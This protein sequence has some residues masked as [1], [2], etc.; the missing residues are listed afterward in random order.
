MDEPE[1]GERETLPHRV[2][3]Q[4]DAAC[5]SILVTFH[6][7]LGGKDHYLASIVE[8]T[9]CNDNVCDRKITLSLI[10]TTQKSMEG[11]NNTSYTLVFYLLYQPIQLWSQYCSCPPPP[12]GHL[13]RSHTDRRGRGG[14]CVRDDYRGERL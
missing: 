8:N 3:S 13:V 2:D 12:I 7:K 6:L 14:K 10:S 11:S 1:G 5:C 4:L 9:L